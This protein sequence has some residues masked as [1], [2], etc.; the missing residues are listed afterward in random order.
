MS[1]LA[2]TID[3]LVKRVSFPQSFS[4]KE[5]PLISK[6]LTDGSLKLR[7]ISNHFL[8]AEVMFECLEHMDVKDVSDWAVGTAYAEGD[9]VKQTYEGKS[10]VFISLQDNNTGNDPAE[11]DPSGN[12]EF[13]ETAFSYKLREY[14]VDSAEEVVQNIVSSFS[15]SHFANTYLYTGSLIN[16]PLKEESVQKSGRFVGYAIRPSD[17]SQTKEVEIQKIGL[18][19]SQDS[20]DV[21]LYHS[22][23]EEPLQIINLDTSASNG[24]FAWY[25]FPSAF[26]LSAFGVENEGGEYY[27]GIYESDVSSDY[28][29]LTSAVITPRYSLFHGA[30]YIRT[31]SVEST[32]LN[33][34]NL[35]S[36]GVFLDSVNTEYLVP[37]NLRL[38]VRRNYYLKMVSNIGFLD[39]VYKYKLAISLLQDIMYSDRVN[40]IVDN[41]QA[42]I[43][44]L[45]YGDPSND[46]NKGLVHIYESHLEQAHMDMKC[47]FESFQGAYQGPI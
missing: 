7:S 46:R 45:L 23:K 13:W 9:K 5:V 8:N 29:G 12:N 40:K 28:K 31:V 27:L 33:K 39:N 35:P 22:S 14:M 41:A 44:E 16:V 2:L 30:A 38:S 6:D 3:E 15:V 18:N 43:D 47:L 36:V 21:Y 34:P 25:S 4:K 37:F 17:Y 10:V 11:Y 42:K 26:L 32:Y 1:T 24:K 20:I 19:V